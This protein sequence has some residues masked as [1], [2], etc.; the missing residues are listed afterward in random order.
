MKMKYNISYLLSLCKWRNATVRVPEVVDSPGVF[1]IRHYCLLDGKTTYL[2]WKKWPK[3]VICIYKAVSFFHPPQT[4]HIIYSLCGIHTSSI[5]YFFP[6][7]LIMSNDPTATPHV[8]LHLKYS[9][10]ISVLDRGVTLITIFT[11]LDN[12]ICTGA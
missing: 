1:S 6:C 7:P 10:K 9:G 5:L 3:R 4:N 2:L 8:N 11:S 12:I